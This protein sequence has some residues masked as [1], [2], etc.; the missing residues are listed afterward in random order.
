MAD[1]C[2]DCSIPYIGAN[3][4]TRFSYLTLVRG[5][6]IATSLK[7]A[8]FTN[9]MANTQTQTSCLPSP[10]IAKVP[11]ELLREIFGLS[12]TRE[13]WLQP[14][15]NGELPTFDTSALSISCVSYT[16]RA[17]ALYSPE[18]WTTMAVY[19]PSPKALD[20]ANLYLSRA[21]SG[22]PL[23]LFL[24][25][26][27]V[28]SWPNRESDDDEH[29]NES[30]MALIDLW[31]LQAERW[32]S[33][34]FH[35]RGGPVPASLM[36][37]PPDKF[38]L[39][40]DV[41]IHPG[42]SG[43]F[44][45]RC[46]LSKF[47]DNINSLPTLRTAHWGSGVPL[48]APFKQLTTFSLCR[49]PLATAYEVLRRCHRLEH[50][51][52]EF[53]YGEEALSHLH[54]AAPIRLPLLRILH[55]G[56]DKDSTRTETFLRNISTPRL[57]ELVLHRIPPA[58]L[59]SI[60]KRSKCTLRSLIIHFVS[61]R[62]R[63]IQCLRSL[64]GMGLLDGLERL[65]LRGYYPNSIFRLFQ[66][67]RAPVPRITF[68]SLLSLQVGSANSP[69]DGKIGEMLLSRAKAGVCLRLFSCN[70][71][72]F[73]LPVNP[74]DTQTFKELEELGSVCKVDNS[75]WY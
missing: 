15:P 42:P 69:S 4:T 63:I 53:E 46:I 45:E 67:S 65:E 40:R 8:S 38:P 20:L 50:F 57:Q 70:V 60:L 55:L 61:P 37:T 12:T 2:I 64:E 18:L 56:T 54:M 39:L 62:K 71:L 19:N 23:S 3:A 72:A 43:N 36:S 68:P 25:E 34:Y 35:F 7:T 9:T 58:A 30:P 16:W 13:P 29:H 6:Y 28:R 47:W 21:G 26:R 44:H 33:L 49:V 27:A 24:T 5:C 66:I 48:S 17:I 10:P 31:L 41:A 22:T 74:K 11:T 32:Q 73:V 59:E 14:H 52:I 1:L 51:T 75:S